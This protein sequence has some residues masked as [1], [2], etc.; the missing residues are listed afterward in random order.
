MLCAYSATTS[1]NTERAVGAACCVCSGQAIA[2]W[3]GTLELK[4]SE[5][6]DSNECQCIVRIA[7]M[8]SCAGAIAVPGMQGSAIRFSITFSL[9]RCPRARHA[10]RYHSAPH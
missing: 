9:S 8:A 7:D 4:D 1:K 3:D 6:I 5:C 10:F 2:G